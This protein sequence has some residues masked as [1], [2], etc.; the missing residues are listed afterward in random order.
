MYRGVSGYANVVAQH[1]GVRRGHPVVEAA[2]RLLHTVPGHKSDVARETEEVQ[3]GF[4]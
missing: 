1:L 3:W 4:R 2:Q